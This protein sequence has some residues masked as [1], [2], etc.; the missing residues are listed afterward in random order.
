MDRYTFAE[1]VAADFAASNNRF[2]KF[3]ADPTFWDFLMQLF[4]KLMPL[5]TGCF[6]SAKEAAAAAQENTLRGRFV[7]SRLSREIRDELDD[8]G[9]SGEMTTPLVTSI[10]NVAA[11]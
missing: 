10:L 11:A 9:L 6:P 7:R 3:K 8:S 5:V 1:N 4:D 2:A